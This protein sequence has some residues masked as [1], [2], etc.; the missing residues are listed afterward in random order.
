M[1]RGLKETEDVPHER[2]CL[3]TTC[4]GRPLLLHVS[5]TE[6]ALGA[7]LAQHDDT[8]QKERAIYYLSKSLLDYETRYTQIEKR[9]LAVV[10]ATKKLRHYML[11]HSVKL[12]ARM[13]P[14]KYVIKAGNK[15][16]S[17]N[18]HP[19]GLNALVKALRPLLT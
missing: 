5:I 19:V 8:R 11:S 6:T 4:A 16:S 12:L 18:E 15:P 3:I 13:D 9:C 2:T 10:W 17:A 1:S 14:L 7:V